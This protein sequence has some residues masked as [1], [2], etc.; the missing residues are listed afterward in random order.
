MLLSSFMGV[1]TKNTKLHPHSRSK[2]IRVRTLQ[3][4][5]DFSHHT[6]T[7]PSRD[8][9]QP[10]TVCLHLQNKGKITQHT[11]FSSNIQEHTK[12]STFGLIFIATNA[13]SSL[14]LQ[15]RVSFLPL[16]VCKVFTLLIYCVCLLHIAIVF[17]YGYMCK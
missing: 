16:H 15:R 1:L 17:C 11:G 6:F 3:A 4:G 9:S 14:K 13:K 7:F 5:H 10:S 8:F 2:N 12:P